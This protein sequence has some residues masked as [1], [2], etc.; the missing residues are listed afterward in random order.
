[1]SNQEWTP[2]ALIEVI[3]VQA[4]CG[5]EDLP[6][7]YET[8]DEFR[9]STAAYHGT[10]DQQIDRAA[11]KVKARMQKGKEDTPQEVGLTGLIR[12]RRLQRR[13]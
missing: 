11:E 13:G 5:E 9:K 6:L 2:E 12:A 1:M 10:I 7:L 3:K 8:L 4:G